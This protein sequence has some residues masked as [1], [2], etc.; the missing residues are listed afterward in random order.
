MDD[1]PGP[2]ATK[3]WHKVRDHHMDSGHASG[4]FIISHLS[5]QFLTTQFQLQVARPSL[6]RHLCL[7]QKG[8]RAAL[9]V[10]ARPKDWLK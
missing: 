4:K 5:S 8:A 6:G 2:H 1:S 9:V 3:K 7:Y 10:H